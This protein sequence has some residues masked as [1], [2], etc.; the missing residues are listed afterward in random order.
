MALIGVNGG[1]VGSQR[2]AN[3]GAASGM[4]TANEQT[5]LRRAGLWL[6]SDPDVAAYIAAVEAADGQTLEDGVKAAINSFVLGCKADGTWTAIKASCILAGA[7]TLSGA[8]V[9]LVGTA[10]TNNNFVSGDYDR[11]TGLVGN[12]STKNLDSNRNHQTDPQNS[13]HMSCFVSTIS[14]SANNGTMIGS[15]YTA[16]GWSFIVSRTSS[17][18]PANR[19]EFGLAQGTYP[20]GVTRSTG[21]V[22]TSRSNS[23][24][25]TGR[26]GSASATY[27]AS[28]QSPNAGDVSIFTGTP[29]APTDHVNARLAFYSI[30]ESIDLALLDTRVTT[31]INAIAAAIP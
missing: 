8:L 30:G 14:T 18:S 27:T 16:T 28:S 26:A 19:Y 17:G 6:I 29:S 9:P 31:L 1:L 13:R 15:P 4:W 23:S 22:G 11:E 3:V 24:N 10:P 5:L 21:F 12:G 7:R 20:S 2:S 25:Y